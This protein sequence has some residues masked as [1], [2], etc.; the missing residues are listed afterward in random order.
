MIKSLCRGTL[1]FTPL[2]YLKTIKALLPAVS[3]KWVYFFTFAVTENLPIIPDEWEFSPLARE[4][5][6]LFLSVSNAR[7]TVIEPLLKQLDVSNK[8]NNIDSPLGYF[9]QRNENFGLAR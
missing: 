3:L 2:A 4:L 8:R 5:S 9:G 1:L 6:S 7:C